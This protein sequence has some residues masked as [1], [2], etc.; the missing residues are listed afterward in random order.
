[1][2]FGTL[3]AV[4]FGKLDVWYTAWYTTPVGT[5]SGFFWYAR[6]VIGY[7]RYVWYNIY[8]WYTSCLSY[9]KDRISV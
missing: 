3:G 7:F 9:T 6:I 4:H 1:M 8:V 5:L 2:S